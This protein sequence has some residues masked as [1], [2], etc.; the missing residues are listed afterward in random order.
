MRLRGRNDLEA[1]ASIGVV[2]RPDGAD[3]Q[4]LLHHGGRLAGAAFSVNR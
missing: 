2:G 3:A 1:K 4:V